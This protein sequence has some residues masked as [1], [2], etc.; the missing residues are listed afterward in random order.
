M[1]DTLKLCYWIQG[2]V[3]IVDKTPT[4][5]QWTEIRQRIEDCDTSNESGEGAMS[6]ETFMTW[7]SGFILLANPK[8]V[9]DAQWDVIKE[10]L[11][12]VFTKVT[13]KSVNDDGD[14]ID[15]DDIL[16]QLQEKKDEIK[17]TPPYTLPPGSNPLEVICGPGQSLP[18]NLDTYCVNSDVACSTA[19]PIG[20]AN[21]TTDTALVNDENITFTDTVDKK[22]RELPQRSRRLCSKMPD[23]YDIYLADPVN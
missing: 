21:P 1:N 6:A 9:T 7:I 10:H 23:A 4:K 13:V 8:S 16:K 22:K 3:E 15:V 19:N 18:N 20:G 17:H 2:F 12:L 11:Q 14:E 5:P